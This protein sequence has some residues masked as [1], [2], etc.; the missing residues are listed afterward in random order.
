LGIE[1]FNAN[2]SNLMLSYIKCTDG[3]ITRSKC[4]IIINCGPQNQSKNV[5]PKT[6]KNKLDPLIKLT[7]NL[8]DKRMMCVTH[9][10]VFAE[11]FNWNFCKMEG[12][13]GD[14][15]RRNVENTI[16]FF[17]RFQVL[18][19]I[20]KSTHLET[21]LWVC[22]VENKMSMVCSLF[23]YFLIQ[24]IQRHL[25]IKIVTKIWNGLKFWDTG[26]MV[27]HVRV[28]ELKNFP[29]YVLP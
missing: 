28:G 11:I 4:V 6:W 12:L 25:R 24:V 13:D 21:S 19:P 2:K 3:V 8:E 16:L 9:P 26:I 18:H 27:F 15:L 17:R 23:V 5:M 14:C 20:L 1:E 29:F 7:V 22:S 10:V